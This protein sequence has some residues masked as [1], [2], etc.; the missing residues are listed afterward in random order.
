M[1][2]YL[3]IEIGGSKLQLGISQPDQLLLAKLVRHD[4]NSQRGAG[5]IRQQI[6]AAA[7]ALLKEYQ[8]ARVGIGFGGPVDAASG[9]TTTSHQVE[10]WDQFPLVDWCR[11]ELGLPAVLGNDCDVAGLAEAT[12]GA[13]QGCRRVFY[14][15][16]GTGIGG[17]LLVDGRSAGACRPAIAEIGH[18]RPG[19]S[20]SSSQQ[21]VESRAS[22]RA[23]EEAVRKRLG[24]D[25]QSDA[26]RELL[27]ACQNDSSLLNCEMIARA[28]SA[29][30]PLA[31]QVIAEAV[32][33][34]GW[35]IAQVITITA[36]EIVVVGGGVSLMDDQLFLEPLKH[37]VS[38]FV[39]GPLAESYRI[40]RAM[41]G[42]DV[43]VQG[44]IALAAAE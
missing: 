6:L 20:A 25:S 2:C 24:Q 1:P 17:G 28:A 29:G 16:V 13:G 38:R 31:G 43:V 35:A 44:A 4:I 37:Q 26:A 12:L 3:G 19:V 10:G 32:E 18:L 34:L 15:T 33:T 30:N 39:F 23:I 8:P 36:P 27:H 5:E 21:T 22:G 14:L 7:A 42:E 9:I 40:C 41:L 11:Q